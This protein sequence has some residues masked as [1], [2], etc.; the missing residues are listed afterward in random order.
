MTKRGPGQPTKFRPDFHPNDFLRLARQ[1]KSIIQIA[2]IWDVDRETIYNWDKKCPEFLGTIKKGQL[3]MEAW[4]SDLGQAAMLGQA[5]LNGQKIK[6]DLGYFVWMSKN[7][8]KWSDRVKND[9]S[10]NVKSEEDVRVKVTLT[11]P[12]NGSEEI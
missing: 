1:G 4:Y 10:V 3:L 6:V 8:C 5:T 9:D 11:L 12:K 7:I 2:A